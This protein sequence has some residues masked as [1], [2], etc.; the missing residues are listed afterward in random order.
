MEN[1][2]NEE[3]FFIPSKKISTNFNNT[4]AI[5]DQGE[6]YG[7]G[8]AYMDKLGL[9]TSLVDFIPDPLVF[10]F[11]KAKQ[12][13]VVDISLGADHV[14]AI[15]KRKDGLKTAMGTVYSWG[16]DL[17]GR[18]GYLSELIKN[19]DEELAENDNYVFRRVPQ[20]ISLSESVVRV[21]CGAD[22]SACITNSGKLY[23]WGTNESGNLGINQ[24]TEE[25][26]NKGYVNTPQ[27]VSKLK[28]QVII[29]VACG[30]KHML[31]LTEERRVYSWGDGK[32]GKLGHGD[33]DRIPTPLKIEE[34]S[35]EDIIFIAA[36]DQ[37]SAAINSKG[38]IYTWGSG[39]YGRLG[40][41]TNEI[42]KTP[43][44][45]TDQ[46]IIN[47]RIFYI[48]LGKYHTVCTSCM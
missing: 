29:Q 45:I 48:S 36:G 6:L 43:K 3:K 44:K 33:C 32:Y 11:F 15:G 1:N 13:K 28:D 14:L 41:G 37:T 10:E 47:E 46:V 9:K 18:L 39:Q 21:A 38:Q 5:N 19:D 42:V 16:L 17:F 8:N 23:T 12:L 7:W 30:D 26:L 25:Y 31:A 27:L 22:F 4:I 34:I 24:S 40:L 35:S 2:K 20:P